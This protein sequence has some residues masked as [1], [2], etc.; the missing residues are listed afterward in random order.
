MAMA[1]AAV[2][3]DGA[4]E[5]VEG[6]EQR[7]GAM[8]FVVMSEGAAAALLQ[9][10]AGLGAVKGLD[11]A[12]LVHAQHQRVHWRVEIEAN[13]IAQ[14]LDK[15][16]VSRELERLD[17]MRPTRCGCKPCAR[18]IRLMVALLTPWALAMVRQLQ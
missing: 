8:A 17:T 12:L 9:R 10:Q 2:A 11:L 6:G 3:D 14:F 16:R 18:Q 5:H 4:I 1:L 7:G 13:H 15:L